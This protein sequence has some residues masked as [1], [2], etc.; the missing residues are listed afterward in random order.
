[1]KSILV[2]VDGSRHSIKALQFAAARKK[3]DG[4]K[5]HI[6]FI[7]RDPPPSRYAP[8]SLVEKWQDQ[9]RKKALSNG[10]VLKLKSKT[11]ARVHVMYGEPAPAILKFA[12]DKAISEIVMGTR[13]MS[14]MKGLLMG[15]VA[16][17]VAQLA[18]VPVTLV[19]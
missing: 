18:S 13:G 11:G 19:K 14:A 16:S 9:Q 1:M 15:S 6:L 8:I 4:S 10:R 2:P 3:Y 5:I 7:Q 17:K 12:R